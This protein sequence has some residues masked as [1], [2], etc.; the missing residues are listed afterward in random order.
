MSDNNEILKRLNETDKLIDKAVTG[1]IAI[2]AKLTQQLSVAISGHKDTQKV[3]GRV[4]DQMKGFDFV[5]SGVKDRPGIVDQINKQ[6]QAIKD[7]T[8][9]KDRAVTIFT[10]SQIVIVLI[11]SGA[12]LAVKAGWL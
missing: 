6:E 5:L 12:T 9:F 8:K 10:V 2:N 1:Q 3:I 4:L 7:L 11:Y